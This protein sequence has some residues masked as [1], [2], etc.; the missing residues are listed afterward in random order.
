MK[1]NNRK[2][3]SPP[4]QR[5]QSTLLPVI[6]YFIEEKRPKEKKMTPEEKTFAD[7]TDDLARM[8]YE[9]IHRQTE[10][11]WS[12]HYK[13]DLY[14]Q[15]AAKHFPECEINSGTYEPQ[16]CLDRM[17]RAQLARDQKHGTEL[18]PYQFTQASELEDKTEIQHAAE[19]L[20]ELLLRGSRNRASNKIVD[21]ASLGIVARIIHEG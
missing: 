10:R 19:E 9:Q 8:R 4:S 3:L 16:V 5:W 17:V 18:D 21:L 12:R 13:R 14:R 7:F 6:N 1:K 2:G 15:L 11:A 20:K